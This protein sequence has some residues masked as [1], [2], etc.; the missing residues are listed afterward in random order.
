ML[1][2][3]YCRGYLRRHFH[4]VRIARDHL[5]ASL[6]GPVI[7]CLNHPAWWDP[8]LCIYLATELFSE[9][10]HFGAIDHQMLRRY[11]FFGRLGLFG[12]DRTAGGARNF[13]R[14]TG[15]ILERPDSMLWLTA[16][17]KFVDPRTRPV[18]LAPGIGHLLHR[19]QHGFVLPLAIEFPF[20][21]ERTPEALLRFGQ[22]VNLSTEACKSPREWTSLLEKRMEET[23]D[24]L[25]RDSMSRNAAAFETTLAGR[26]G[27]GGIYDAFGRLKARLTGRRFRAEHGEL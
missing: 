11:R 8:I 27:A 2:G 6:S 1:F 24:E 20:W 9:N 14:T 4:A 19:Q 17:G 26:A 7:V 5:P 12:V 23:Q 25:A 21:Q 10:R 16:E 15:A 22:P 18:R 3:K 13:L